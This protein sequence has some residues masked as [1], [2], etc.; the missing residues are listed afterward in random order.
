[1]VQHRQNRIGMKYESHFCAVSLHLPTRQKTIFETI[2]VI[3]VRRTWQIISLPLIFHKLY[4]IINL[5]TM[6]KSHKHFHL[7][8]NG[9]K[10]TKNS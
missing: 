4:H 6:D 3:S 5:N 8:R 2:Q 7:E 10:C 9:I 1:M